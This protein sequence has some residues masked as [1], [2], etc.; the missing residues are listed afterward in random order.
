MDPA[1][2]IGIL[3]ALIG[4]LVAVILEGG[5]PLAFLNLPS[6]FIVFVGTAGVT[7]ASVRLKGFANVPRLIVKGLKS[8]RGMDGS[9]V[10]GTLVRLAER[11]RREGLLAIEEDLAEVP[12]PFLR[13]GLQMVVDGTDPEVVRDVLRADIDGMAERHRRGYTMFLTAG[14]FSPTL[15]IIGTVMG[16]VHVLEQLADPNELGPS[17]AVAFIATLYGVAAANVFYLPM[18]NKLKALSEEEL[19]LRELAVDGILAI[20]AG[21]N[22]RIIGEKLA[23][24]LPPAKPKPE[25]QASADSAAAVA[26]E[27]PA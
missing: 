12:D 6:F 15:G 10:V 21:E 19:E 20:Q 27:E 5:N 16:L 11:A 26:A 2:L 25:R 14:G 8:A 23:S 18:A 9:E 7:M 22:P 1:T 13:K 4:L 24:Y 17:I 3:L